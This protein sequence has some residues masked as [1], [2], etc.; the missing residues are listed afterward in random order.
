MG[1]LPGSSDDGKVG[2]GIDLVH[3]V[4]HAMLEITVLG[5][6]WVLRDALNII[7]VTDDLRTAVEQTTTY[8]SINPQEL[9]S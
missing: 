5:T 6:Y 4:D 1:I 3:L 8:I 9:Q 2:T 7:L